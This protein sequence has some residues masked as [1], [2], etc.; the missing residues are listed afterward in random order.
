MSHF[1]EKEKMILSATD[2][3]YKYI[4]RE[5]ERPN[6]NLYITDRQSIDPNVASVACIN[7]FNNYFKGVRWIDGYICFRKPILDNAEKKYLKNVIMPFI[8]RVDGITKIETYLFNKQFIKISLED[9][10]PI[11]FPC[12]KRNM[13]Y[14]NMAPGKKYTLEELGLARHQLSK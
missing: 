3:K 7:G 4:R 13:M 14:K 12:F 11:S 10:E 8:D 1:T 9:D 6:S 5:S 2:K